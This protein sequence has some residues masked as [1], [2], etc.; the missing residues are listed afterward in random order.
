MKI[1][2]IYIGDRE[3]MKNFTSQI[4]SGYMSY[5]HICIH[6]DMYLGHLEILF[7]IYDQKW[8]YTDR[9][10][11]ANCAFLTC[12]NENATEPLFVESGFTFHQTNLPTVSMFLAFLF[13]CQLLCVVGNLIIVNYC[14][15]EFT[16][17]FYILLGIQIGPILEYCLWMNKEEISV[18]MLRDAPPPPD[19]LVQVMSGIQ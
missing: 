2:A 11:W 9:P 13:F 16:V 15:L 14:T 6:K 7:T 12:S 18:A 10:C 4:V 8:L 5:I 19:D 3:N 1:Q 17:S